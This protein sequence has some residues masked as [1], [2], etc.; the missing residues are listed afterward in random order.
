[1]TET[2]GVGGDGLGHVSLEGWKLSGKRIVYM[3]VSPPRL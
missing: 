3:S 1:M 2:M